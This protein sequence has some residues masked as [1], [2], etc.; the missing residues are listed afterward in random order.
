MAIRTRRLRNGKIAYDVE[1]RRPDGTKYSKTFHAKRDAQAWEAEQRA[2][3]ARDR[4]IDPTAGRVT[5]RTY[6]DE[7]MRTRRLAPRTQ[8]VYA[9]QLKHIVATFGDTPLNAITR[10]AVRLWARRFVST[11]EPVAGGEVLPAPDGVPEHRRRGRPHRQEPVPG[12][13]RGVGDQRRTTAD[14]SQRRSRTRA[15]H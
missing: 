5:L 2:D 13:Q 6:A 3:R 12:P 14:P 1:L 15:G 10:R 4:W 9:S 8:E 11:R 7:W